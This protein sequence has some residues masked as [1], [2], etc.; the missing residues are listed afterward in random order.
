MQLRTYDKAS[1]DRRRRAGHRG[2]VALQP[3]ARGACAR[4]VAVTGEKG[5]E[6]ALDTQ[7]PPALILLDLMLP[8][9]VRA[10][11]CAAASG[12]SP[13][14]AARP[15]SCSR[16]AAPRPT[17]SRGSSSARTTT[18]PSPSPCASWWRASAPCCAARTTPPPR[19]TRTSGSQV[20]F[21]DMHV[22][23]DGAEVR[24]T[25]KEFAL[26]SALARRPGPRRH[27]P[28]TARRRLGPAI[29][30]RHAHARRA[31]PPPAPEARPLRRLH[32]DGR[33]RRLPLRRLLGQSW[34]PNRRPARVV[35]RTPRPPA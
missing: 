15:S 10:R 33:R 22:L 5:L 27:A 4:V 24:L 29:L 13:R 9:H 32:R 23:C 17:A 26:L 12:A 6:L 14:P 2:G 3:R 7:N 25:R 16:R 1:A 30:R 28:A 35:R 20:H 11:S 34:R 18:S 21:E 8:G 31:H 19:A